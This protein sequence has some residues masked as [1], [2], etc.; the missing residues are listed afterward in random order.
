M[1]TKNLTIFASGN[2]TNAENLV[3]YFEGSNTKIKLILSNNPDAFVLK[4]AESLGVAS[5]LFTR[6][7][8][9]DPSNLLAYLKSQ[10]IDWIILAGFI[11]WLPTH[12]VD[13]YPNHI[14]NIHPSLLP[15]FGGKGMIGDKVH[16]AVK[17][18]GE[19][20]TGM[21]IHYVNPVLD[22]GQIIFQAKCNLTEEDTV[23][24]ISAKVHGLEME[25]FPK[26]IERLVNEQ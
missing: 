17:A 13:A 23:E 16:E 12:F 19:T 2:G 1:N 21:T 26:V 15:K 22:G 14:I 4:R 5:K 20:E 10:D 18:A 24:T 9:N 3:R 6:G 25:H 7:E 8:M 11:W